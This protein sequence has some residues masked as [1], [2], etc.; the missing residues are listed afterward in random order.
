MVGLPVNGYIHP[1]QFLKTGDHYTTSIAA[2]IY[3]P[4][5]LIGKCYYSGAQIQC[6][7]ICHDP[8]SLSRI[9]SATLSTLA[10]QDIQY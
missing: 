7:S 8:A 6:V 2:Y 10:D 4:C 9:G 5:F 1:R 3:G